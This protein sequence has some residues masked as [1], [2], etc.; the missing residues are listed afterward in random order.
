[1]CITY[2]SIFCSVNKPHFIYSNNNYLFVYEV[3]LLNYKKNPIIFGTLLL[4]ISGL[5]CRGIGFLYRLF[6]SKA[7]GE[8]AMGIFQLT[9]PVLMLAFSLTCAANQTAVSRYTASCLGKNNEFL[10]KKF[11]LTGCFLSFLPALLYSILVY[12]QAENISIYLLREKR[13][14]DLLKISALSFPFS[15]LH[16]C[17]NGYF[18]GKKNT[19]TPSFTQIFEQLIRVGSVLYLYY[20]L[21][22][23]NRVPTIT[24]TCVGMVLG[25]VSSFLLSLLYYLYSNMKDKNQLRSEG[26]NYKISSVTDTL[27]ENDKNPGFLSIGQQLLSFTVPL[28]LNRVIV[29]LLQSYES[30]SIPSYLKEYGYS[31]EISLSIYGVLTGMALSLVLF[32]STFA[33]SVSVLLLPTIAEASSVKN[34]LEIK[35]TI[36][37]SIIFS[38]ILGTVCTF[39]FYLSG[40]LC[41]ILLF[42]SPLA[43]KFI[44]YL[45]FLCPFLYLHITLG[46]IL[47]GLQKTTSTLFINISSLLFRLFFVLC[48]IPQYGIKAY[49]WG[50]LLSELLASIC[51]IYTLRKNIF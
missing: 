18:Y 49:L 46:S 25:E 35:K 37:K 4:S 30:I 27:H 20:F 23:H 39:T 8:E 9:A 42:D 44:R 10:A 16:S 13:C 7:F 17:F 6:I 5:L 32:P 12:Q 19:K 33:N 24:L 41:G 48:L 38:L 11:L 3:F 28:T 1:M 50:L 26:S 29:N 15:A 40:D 14:T 31:Q 45:S 43:G 36:L 2:H 34:F 22:N 51:C 47:N 21:S